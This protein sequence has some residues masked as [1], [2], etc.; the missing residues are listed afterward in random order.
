LKVLLG[1]YEMSIHPKTMPADQL[2]TGVNT[3]LRRCLDLLLRI[4]EEVLPLVSRPIS[5]TLRAALQDIDLLSQCIDDI[6]RCV[7][8]IAA[9][10]MAEIT[11]DSEAILA[12]IRLQDM[13]LRLEGG[14]YDARKLVNREDMFDAP[15]TA[16]AGHQLF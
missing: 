3:E 2:L 5:P 7:C 12:P 6:S 9:A 8:G 1:S 16:A 14:V 11:L 10:D 15:Q 13:R 4:E